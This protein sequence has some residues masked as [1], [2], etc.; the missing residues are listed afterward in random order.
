VTDA[1]SGEQ[2]FAG[3]F[4]A[5]ENTSTKVATLVRVEYWQKRLLLIR[6]TANGEEGFNHYLAGYPPFDFKWYSDLM[7]K[8][9]L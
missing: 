5:P 2:L 1:E 3:E 4:S 8:H 7:Q 6:W 9:L